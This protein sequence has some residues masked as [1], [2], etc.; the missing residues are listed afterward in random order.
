MHPAEF[1]FSCSLAY[2]CFNLAL[3]RGFLEEESVFSVLKQAHCYLVAAFSLFGHIWVC[4]PIGGLPSWKLLSHCLLMLFSLDT[5]LCWPCI[6]SACLTCFFYFLSLRYHSLG[7]MWSPLFSVCF[8]LGYFTSSISCS[9]YH[10]CRAY[11]REIAAKKQLIK[12]QMRTT[13]NWRNWRFCR[14]LLNAPQF[15][16]VGQ[17]F[18]T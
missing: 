17:S 10:L 13:C 15:F 16:P 18:R 5:Q 6:H 14:L 11:L 7:L 1:P 3:H 2:F 12:V 9:L 4:W 8:Q